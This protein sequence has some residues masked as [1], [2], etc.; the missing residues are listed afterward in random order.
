MSVKRH[1]IPK[2]K[3]ASARLRKLIE[4]YYNAINQGNR[5]NLPYSCPLVSRAWNAMAVNAT[6]QKKTS[7]MPVM[8]TLFGTT[9]WTHSHQAYNVAHEYAR[10]FAPP[11]QFNRKSFNPDSS[12]LPLTLF[13]DKCTSYTFS[14]KAV[15]AR[16]EWRVTA[17]LLFA[18]MLESEGW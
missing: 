17:L 9:H 11:S 5:G 13:G 7:A 8:I 15:K 2:H 1:R 16:D 18:E 4:H 10:L 6:C 3:R 12:W 14:T